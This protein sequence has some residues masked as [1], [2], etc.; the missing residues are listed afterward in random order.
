MER[1]QITLKDV[2]KKDD[3][4]NLRYSIYFKNYNDNI[5][6]KITSLCNKLKLISRAEVFNE[7][8]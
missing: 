2:M 3:E 6:S 5:L 4:Y 7:N 8:L 1:S